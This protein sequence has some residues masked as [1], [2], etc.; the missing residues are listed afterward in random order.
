MMV[1]NEV[2]SEVP[3]PCEQL[4]GRACDLLRQ[5]RVQADLALIPLLVV[6]TGEVTRIGGPA[7]GVVRA[8]LMVATGVS[9][10]G[11]LCWVVRARSMVVRALGDLR[12]RTG[13][14]VQRVPWTAVGIDRPFEAVA[15][16][17]ELRNLLGAAYGCCRYSEIAVAW[18]V[19]TLVLH[20]FTWG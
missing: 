9:F 1:E 11:A 10:L 18:S 4:L 2:G 7:P 8:A 17:R 6:L 13:A 12:I 5:S 3:E 14:P 15:L 19:V 20:V 16:G